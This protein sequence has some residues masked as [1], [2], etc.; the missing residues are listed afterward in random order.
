MPNAECP[1]RF[2]PHYEYGD[3]VLQAVTDAILS[4]GEFEELLKPILSMAYRYAARLVGKSEEAMDLVQD[5]SVQAFRARHTFQVGSNFKAWFM[6]ILTNLHYAQRQKK[7]IETTDIED[8]PDAILYE[9][10][11]RTGADLSGDDPAAWFFNKVDMDQI[12]DALDHL[13]DDY[14]EAAMLYFISDMSYEEI[15]QTLDVPIGTVRSRLHRARKH[16][17]SALWELAV[18]RGWVE[19]AGVGA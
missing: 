12:G 14:R 10:A 8:A 5:A 17:Q 1:P 3:G 15:S 16:L 2:L 13:P 11:K 18:D 4:K 7:R 19:E 9:H 6:K